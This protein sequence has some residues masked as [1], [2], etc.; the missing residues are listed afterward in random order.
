MSDVLGEVL[1][2]DDERVNCTLLARRLEHRGYRVD[3]A[4]EGRAA[5]AKI[6]D[7]HYDLVL[8]DVMMPGIDGLEVLRKIRILKSRAQLPVIMVTGRDESE[9]IVEALRRG[10]NDYVTKPID[11][12]VLLARIGTHVVLKRTTESLEQMNLR[13]EEMNAQLRIDLDAAAR[14]QQS[15][16]PRRTPRFENFE[17]AWKYEPCAKLAG[18]NLDIMSLDDDDVGFYVLDVSGHG[19][20]AAL[21]SVA[22]NH[23]LEPGIDDTSLVSRPNRSRR[24][25]SDPRY[26]VTPPAEV[27][28]KLNRHFSFD[29]ATGQYFTL[30]YGVIDLQQ[31][32][33]RYVSTGHPSPVR[34]TAAGEFEL[35]ES[36]G[37]PIGLFQK[38][39]AH[40]EPYEERTIALKSGDRLYVYSDGV[41]EARNPVKAEFG[42]NRLVDLLQKLR[43]TTL[44]RSVEATFAA[45]EEWREG[46]PPRDDLTM[47]ALDVR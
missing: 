29:P 31:K 37:T 28:E 14:I 6:A 25:E 47:V 18:D 44:D 43:D 4:Q 40:Y 1:V 15:H 27:A 45:L 36:S 33:C 35:L 16:L 3:V 22:I 8:L 39:D 20:R 10:A 24:S 13:L 11:T 2:V 12:E 32:I 41:I 46:T 42:I 21:M 9:D 19:V 34:L 38:G 17:F 30:L 7:R 5:L 26:V 23:L